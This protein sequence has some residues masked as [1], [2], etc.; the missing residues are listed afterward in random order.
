MAW[1][2]GVVDLIISIEALESY[3][4]LRDALM[5]NPESKEKYSEQQVEKISASTKNF[6][7]QLRRDIGFMFREEKERRNR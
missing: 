7:K 6:R 3:F 5:K 4:Y 2:K 1:K